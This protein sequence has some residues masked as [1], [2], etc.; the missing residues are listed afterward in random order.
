MQFPNSTL[1]RRLPLTR[2][3]KERIPVRAACL[4][5]GIFDIQ[6]PDFP[7]F[8]GVKKD[9]LKAGW[10]K[11]HATRGFDAALL[12]IWILGAFRHYPGLDIPQAINNIPP[13]NPT[14]IYNRLSRA[15]LLHRSKTPKCHQ[16]ADSVSLTARTR[17]AFTD[18]SSPANSSPKTRLRP[19]ATDADIAASTPPTAEEREASARGINSGYRHIACSVTASSQRLSGKKVGQLNASAASAGGRP[20]FSATV[21]EVSNFPASAYA[22]LNS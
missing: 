9:S 11:A 6:A 4:Q 20:R 1:I 15:P 10:A 16:E 8:E 2:C 3:A 17:S 7:F 5:K 18:S 22:R 21:A 13:W 14:G 12:Q 19:A